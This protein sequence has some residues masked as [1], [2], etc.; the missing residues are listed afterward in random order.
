MISGNFGKSTYKN[1]HF[2][3]AVAHFKTEQHFMGLAD[4]IN[5]NGLQSNPETTYEVKH[6]Q[7]PDA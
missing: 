5:K 7:I 3:V 2:Q 1:D 4:V 6:V